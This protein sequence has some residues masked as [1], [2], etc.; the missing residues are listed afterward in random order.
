MMIQKFRYPKKRLYILTIILLCISL[1]TPC[2]ALEPVW[3]YS[4]DG[5]N[6]GGVTISS[7]GSVIAVAAGKIWI[8]SEEKTRPEKKPYGNLIAMTPDGST[9]VSAYFSHLYLFKKLPITNTSFELTKIWEHELQNSV[10]SLAIA[11]AGNT[12]AVTTEGKGVRV[13]NTANGSLLGYTNKYYPLVKVSADGKR[14]EGISQSGLISFINSGR[15]VNRSMDLSIVQQPRVLALTSRGDIGVFNE[16]QKIRRI[17]IS[18]G[19]DLWTTRATGD[20][21]DL[22]M[23]PGGSVVIVGTDNGHIDAFNTK[24]NCSWSYDTHPQSTNYAAVSSVAISDSGSSIAAGTSDGRVILLNSQGEIVDSVQ[25][26]NDHIHYIAMSADGSHIIAAGDETVYAFS[27]QTQNTRRIISRGTPTQQTTVSESY[28][29]IPEEIDSPIP[30]SPEKIVETPA[31]PHEY[32][33]IITAKQS[34]L[35]LTDCVIALLI[36]VFI[37]RKYRS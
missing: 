35:T 3:T 18:N 34:P 6:I 36:L 37:G 19:S 30:Y 20:V 10:I 24:G 23:T 9:I 17:R 33:V 11:D 32:S 1:I 5:A 26:N 15:W 29:P 31:T 2:F 13:Y 22:A 8:F 21:K 16:D 27:S 25:T 7:N 4:E 12:V 28:N 14:V